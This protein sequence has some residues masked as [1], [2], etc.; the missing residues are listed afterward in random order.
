VNVNDE[1]V[2]N[3]VLTNTDV[4]MYDGIPII[5]G[6]KDITEFIRSILGGLILEDNNII[7]KGKDK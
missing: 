1:F 3:W 6:K 7:I 4:V 5:V 2:F